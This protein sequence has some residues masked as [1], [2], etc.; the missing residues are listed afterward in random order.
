MN[1]K[2]LVAIL[3]C[4][5][6]SGCTKK[7][8]DRAEP[9]AAND[10]AAVATQQSETAQTAADNAAAEP[11]TTPVTEQKP[12][13]ILNAAVNAVELGRRMVR[14]A[15]VDF[16]A[17]DVVKTGL[18]IEKLTLEAGGF[19]ELKNIDFRVIDADQQKIADGK[20]KI[21]EKVSPQ[22]D[23]VVRVPSEKA[24]VFVNALLPMMYFLNQ[25]QY[26]A[27][28]FELKLLEE[29]ISQSQTVPSTTR[30]AQQNEIAR[31]TQLEVQDRVNYSTIAIRINQ[32]T[33]VRERI[34]IDINA[35]ANLNGD[36][37]WTRA[38]N[39]LQSGWQ[40]VLDLLVFLITI[41]PLYLVIIIGGLL[42]K[43]IQPIIRRFK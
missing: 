9:A 23:M 28:R 6:L 4:L 12:D 7:A 35:V 11:N 1:N 14:E 39:A 13:S 26:S 16:N 32:P 29:K 22:A 34:D 37:F 18:A 17:Q 24:A 21:F 31:L 19:V 40:F 27:K 43:L 30:N 38:W 2:Y 15:Q 33:L 25:Q 20:I 8:E 5:I 36:G 42:F 41:W 3:A 10:A